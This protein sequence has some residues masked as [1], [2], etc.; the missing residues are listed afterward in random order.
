MIF[1]VWD[2][3]IVPFPFTE[4]LEAKRRPALVV[5]RKLFNQDGHTI[6]AMITSAAHKPWPGDSVL[7]NA[8]AAGLH[9]PC[10]VR[11]KL[12]TLGNRLLL[13]KIG[14][15]HSSDRRSVIESF[16]T[17]LPATGAA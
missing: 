4:R 17:F 1:D 14:H 5:S 12:F 13:R 16:R 3:V 6:L 7:T 9:V 2:V 11:L 15:L 10:L 8:A